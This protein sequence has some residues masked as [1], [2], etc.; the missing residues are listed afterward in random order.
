MI[1][2]PEDI[3]LNE[4]REDQQWLGPPPGWL[5]HWGITFV[6]TAVLLLV[7]LGFW[8]RYPDVVEAHA[9]L[10]TRQPPVRV[11]APVTGR[12]QAWM[13]GEGALVQKN[14]PLGLMENSAR[15]PDILRLDTLLDHF[16]PQ[17]E[18]EWLP[19]SDLP[20]GLSLGTLQDDYA[21]FYQ[22]FENLRY[23]LSQDATEQRI[24][25]MQEQIAQI[26]A[27]EPV[28]KQQ[29]IT[30]SQEVQVVNERQQRYRQN[31]PGG[32]ISQYEFE[33]ARQAFLR[34]QRELQDLKRDSINNRRTMASLEEQILALRQN[35]NEG[36]KEAWRQ[37]RDDLKRLH[38]AIAEW[39]RQYLIRSPIDGYV[40]LTGALSEGQSFAQGEEMLAVLPP[41]RDSAYI[42]R[43]GL[44]GQGLGKVETGMQVLLRLDG[45]PYREY[46]ELTGKV[47]SL[48]PI[49]DEGP[50]LY[51]AVIRLD[52]LV[53]SHGAAIYFRQET[54]A[55]A[56]IITRPRSLLQ[57]VFDRLTGGLS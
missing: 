39:D 33:E 10:T 37:L 25:A 50:G 18:K 8:L 52:S 15:Y 24:K 6:L 23:Q 21:L 41:E 13:T 45:Y 11:V 9:I 54:G 35:R 40:A 57:R 44:S 20:S 51:R 2:Q 26:R 16:G 47:A 32:V 31:V 14:S 4:S 3:R 28:L 56:R 1:E 53:T 12:L 48:S 27:L 17:L 38:G 34:A 43:A 49:P 36:V 7:F 42:V 29:S 5:L 46:G 55:T 22:H 30:L 19:E